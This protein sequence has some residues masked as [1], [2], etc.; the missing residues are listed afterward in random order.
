MDQALITINQ[1]LFQLINRTTTDRQ[2][3]IQKSQSTQ[4]LEGLKI[5]AR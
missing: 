2:V 4:P 5:Q 3:P 1:M